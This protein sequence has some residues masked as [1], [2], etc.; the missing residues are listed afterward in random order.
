[1]SSVRWPFC[2]VKYKNFFYTVG[3]KLPPFC[4]QVCDGSTP[5]TMD[6]LMLTSLSVNSM[7]WWLDSFRYELHIMSDHILRDC[8]RNARWYSLNRILHKD[9]RFNTCWLRWHMNLHRQITR[10]LHRCHTR[11]CSVDTRA[12]TVDTRTCAVDTRTCTVDTH[13]C[14]VDTRACTVDTRVLA[15]LKRVLAPLTRVLETAR[16]RR[17]RGR[18]LIIIESEPVSSLSQ[19]LRDRPMQM[20]SSKSNGKWKL[21]YSGAT[22]RPHASF[23]RTPHDDLRLSFI[24]RWQGLLFLPRR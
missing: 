19:L 18:E 7:D 16:R 21:N 3:I 6:A 8:A 24:L 11:A 22:L 15:P 10:A 14:T 9:S 2:D 20:N 13:A 1:M 17:W 4:D 5:R 12:C 23:Y